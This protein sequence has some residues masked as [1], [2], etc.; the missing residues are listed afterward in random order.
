MTRE[1]SLLQLAAATA[2]A[3]AGVLRG[4]L[5]GEVEVSQPQV[6]SPDVSALDGLAVP[7]VAADA[8]YT[9]GS[10]GG[11]LFVTTVAGARRLSATVMGVEP[12]AGGQP[13]DEGELTALSELMAQVMSA[14]ATA[15]SEVLGY[16]VGLSVPK[17]TDIESVVDA[18]S[19][20]ADAQHATRVDVT[21]AG[22][23]WRFAQLV[24]KAFVLRMTHPG[25]GSPRMLEDDDEG[26]QDESPQATDEILRGVRLRVCAEI[27]RT[28]MLS[29]TAV[30][31]PRGGL[32]ELDAGADE[33]IDLLVNG[34][35]FAIGRLVL[36][37]DEWAVRIE[38]VLLDAAELEQRTA[39]PPVE[40]F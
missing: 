7:A 13:L 34:L 1:A 21:V 2:E 6:V 27:G 10:V 4:I 39:S 35:R 14:A 24:P 37:D 38:E 32:I 19:L 36:V 26:P 22:H 18:V 5:P 8:S 3:V 40:R 15:T 11:S 33:P 28:T 12:R 30:T 25:G 16:E 29:S 9:D 17:L 23:T 20:A 31:M